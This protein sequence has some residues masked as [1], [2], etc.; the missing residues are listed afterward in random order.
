M[1]NIPKDSL[2]AVEKFWSYASF[3]RH[4]IGK[5]SDRAFERFDAFETWNPDRREAA[6]EARRDL[7]CGLL[8]AVFNCGKNHGLDLATDRITEIILKP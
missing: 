6:V 8:E 5:F 7:F 1:S 2:E 4:D 3:V